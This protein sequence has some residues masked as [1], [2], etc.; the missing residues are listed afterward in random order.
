MKP[1]PL[2]GILGSRTVGAIKRYQEA[3]GRPPTGNI[4]REL[5]GRL[6]QEKPI[7]QAPAAADVPRQTADDARRADAAASKAAQD[8][9]KPE[10]SLRQQAEKAEAALNL[11]ERDRKRVQ[12]ALTA[13]GYEVPATGYFGPITRAMI[14]DW[15]KEQ[16]LPETGFIDSS[17]LATLQP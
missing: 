10:A 11:S 5:L 9:P 17:Q 3:N 12:M 15:Q 6:R 14:A 8:R 13:L 4:D 2:D 7:S 1:G 16:G